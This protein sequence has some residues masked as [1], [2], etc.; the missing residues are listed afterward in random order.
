M[1]A[2]KEKNFADVFEDFCNLPAYN[3]HIQM[4]L[5]DQYVVRIYIH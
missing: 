1:D 4:I 2:D 3:L 5:N